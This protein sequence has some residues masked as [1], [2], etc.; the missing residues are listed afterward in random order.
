[1]IDRTSR[2]ISFKVQTTTATQ[3]SSKHLFRTGSID[4]HP[5]TIW[6]NFKQS[7]KFHLQIIVGMSLCFRHSTSSRLDSSIRSISFV[8]FRH[9]LSF[10][11]PAL[12]NQKQNIVKQTQKQSSCCF[13]FLFV[14]FVFYFFSLEQHKLT[15]TQ[16]LTH[17]LTPTE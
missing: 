1:M 11:F 2:F 5:N 6:Y 15:R 14:I 9:V 17:R 16:S 4:K 13:L 10:L 12:E 7:S 3:I 8:L